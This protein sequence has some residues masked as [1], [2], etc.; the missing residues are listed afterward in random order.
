MIDEYEVYELVRE[1]YYLENKEDITREEAD[2][3]EYDRLQEWL[4][5]RF[6]FG[7]WSEFVYFI[8]KLIELVPPIQTAIT[9]TWY[10][11]FVS[12]DLIVCR[13]EYNY[14]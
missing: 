3:L 11:A 1:L 13:K 8:D 10:H 14:L 5:D 4:Y 6:E 7:D 2:E 9:K 12:N